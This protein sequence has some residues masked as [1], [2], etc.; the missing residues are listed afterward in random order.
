[1]TTASGSAAKWTTPYQDIWSQGAARWHHPLGII[2]SY[3]VFWC[4]VFQAFKGN[5]W[6][7][8]NLFYLL[9]YNGLISVNSCPNMSNLLKN[10]NQFPVYTYIMTLFIPFES[11]RFYIFYKLF[12][13]LW[14]RHFVRSRQA[15]WCLQ[16]APGPLT[17][18]QSHQWHG[19]GPVA[20][21]G[22]H[23]KGPMP[24]KKIWAVKWNSIEQ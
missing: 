17:V 20:T 19:D 6:N 10:R 22:S 12:H 24:P 16:C 23:H 1:M 11:F 4:A 5:L 21:Q 14:H 15:R 2:V 8:S 13:V 18:L 3:C 7:G 9:Y